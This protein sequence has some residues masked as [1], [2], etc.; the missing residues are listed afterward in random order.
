MRALVRREFDAVRLREQGFDA[1]TADLAAGQG[2]DPAM[3]GVKTLVYLVHTVDRGGS[4][5]ANELE[6]VQ[7]TLLAARRSE[8]ERVIFL[9]SVGA[10]GESLAPYLVARWAAELAVRQS[11]LRWV[12]IRAPLIVG[13]GGALFETLRGAAGRR[14]LGLLFGWRRTLVEP[15]ALADVVA[16][17][18]IAIDD[19]ELDERAFDLC[20]ADRLTVGAFM[21]EWARV[22]GARRLHLPLPGR[23]ERLTVFAAR[24]LGG[25]A[26]RP[27][28]SAAATM[29]RLLETLREPQICTDP[30]ARFPLGRR[31]L[32]CREALAAVLQAD[33]VG[34]T[35]GGA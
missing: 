33:D 13:R 22:S 2:V 29:Q 7:N 27:G 19:R 15:V 24:Q 26:H 31:P 32:G 11:G 14:P 8:V 1:V 23:G 28:G 4:L 18:R 16:A 35:T 10:T 12:I 21:R 30:S 17:L 34:S 20:G 3:R 25:S 6:A 5:V 9:G